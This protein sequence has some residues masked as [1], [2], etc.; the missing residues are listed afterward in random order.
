[1]ISAARFKHRG[2]PL[3]AK[4]VTTR[5]PDAPIPIGHPSTLPAPS[6]RKRTAKSPTVGAVLRELTRRGFVTLKGVETD[7]G[8]VDHLALGPTGVFAVV[9][10][11]WRRH[12]WV[13][14]HPT[15]VVVGRT[16]V[17]DAV[18]EIV[19]RALEI[20]RR[21]A[22]LAPDIVVEALVVVTGIRLPAGPIALGRSTIVDVETL[23]GVVL[24]RPRIVD[25]AMLS[26]LADAVLDG[27]NVATAAFGPDR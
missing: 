9:A 27:G 24:D 1:V 15:R 6:G 11:T 26:R 4:S 23:R 14:A 25:P 16:D 10:K 12:I 19:H 8:I 22:R 3:D 18:R 20:D 7:H 21:V 13:G 5:P 17:T 2:P